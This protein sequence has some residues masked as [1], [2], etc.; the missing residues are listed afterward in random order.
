MLIPYF[1]DNLNKNTIKATNKTLKSGRLSKGSIALKFEKEF[2]KKLSIKSN[3][4]D[5]LSVSSC[6]AALHLV[7]KYLNLKKNDE[8]IIPSLSFVADANTVVH[9][10]AKVI[11]SDIK[12]ADDLTSCPKD[13]KKK[14]NVKTKAVVVMHYGGFPSDILQIRK[15]CKQKKIV[16][17]EDA[18]HALFSSYGKKKLG[19]FGDFSVF[20]FYGNKNLSTGEGGMIISAKKNIEYIKKLSSHG[21]DFQSTSRLKKKT[22]GYNVHFPGLNYRFDDLRATIG[23]NELKYLRD[24][25]LKRFE[26][27]NNYLRLFKKFKLDR[28]VHIPFRK[29]VSKNL[30]FHLFPIVLKKSNNQKIFEKMLTKGVMLSMHYPLIHKFAYYKKINK[31]KLPQSEKISNNI[32]SL[33]IF[34]NLKFKDQNIIVSNLFELLNHEL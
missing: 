22:I 18:C 8:I 23:L 6:T 31:T 20:S 9:C 34:P 12:S 1:D 26:L 4:Y 27:Y 19:T 14:I 29:K 7:F 10:G 24:K 21:I 16:L 30:S 13:I 2:L 3:K 33:P 25:N 11:F 17:I 5:A 15:I 32:L 28:F